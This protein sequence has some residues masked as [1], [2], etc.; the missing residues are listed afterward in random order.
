MIRFVLRAFSL[1]F[2]ILAVL[3]ASFDSIASVAASSMITTSFGSLWKSVDAASLAA[4][5][6]LTET[7]LGQPVWMVIEAGMLRQP[8]F[9]VFLILAL[10]LWMAGYRRPR[11]AG[12]FAA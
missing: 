12:R 3:T 4:F 10:L 2:L 5:R 8:G 1:V 9:A 6:S 7:Y 11:P